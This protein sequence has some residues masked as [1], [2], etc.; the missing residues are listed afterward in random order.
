MA[1]CTRTGHNNKHGP[2]EDGPQ[3]TED[4]TYEEQVKCIWDIYH[5]IESPLTAWVYARSSKDTEGQ[6]K[7][8]DRVAD[9]AQRLLSMT[10]VL[11]HEANYY[12]ED[13]QE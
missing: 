7:A 4:G 10:G 6:E 12:P 1:T 11:Y 3:P 9:F 8:L 2:M 13:N 5:S